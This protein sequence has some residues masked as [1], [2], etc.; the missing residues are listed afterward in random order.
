MMKKTTQRPS[1]LLF[2][3][4]TCDEV[5]DRARANT[6]S[7][8]LVAHLVNKHKLFPMSIRHNAPYAALKS[9]LRPATAEESAKYKD[10][11]GHRRKKVDEGASTGEP[12]ARTTTVVIEVPQ[13]SGHDSD[14]STGKSERLAKGDKRKDRERGHEGKHRDDGDKGSRERAQRDDARKAKETADEKDL[15][16]EETDKRDYVTSQNKMEARR[17]AREIQAA[18]DTLISLR[19]EQATTSSNIA[20]TFRPGSGSDKAKESETSGSRKESSKARASHGTVGEPTK[21]SSTTAMS[22]VSRRGAASKKW[23]SSGERRH[24]SVVA[25]SEKK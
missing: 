11:N 5:E 21:G 9:D 23:T 12:S 17:I 7:Y 3:C 2:K 8:D 14:K 19:S 15:E 4:Q 10:A 18:H 16:E 1:K 20:A 25:R 24:D 22:N 13:G 6:R